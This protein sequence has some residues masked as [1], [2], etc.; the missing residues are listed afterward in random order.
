MAMLC[1]VTE[2]LWKSFEILSV[3]NEWEP[4]PWVFSSDRSSSLDKTQRFFEKA[5]MIV[6]WWALKGTAKWICFL[7]YAVNWKKVLLLMEWK[8]LVPKLD[9]LHTCKFVYFCAAETVLGQISRLNYICKLPVCRKATLICPS[10]LPH[11]SSLAEWWEA[12]NKCVQRATSLASSHLSICFSRL[13]VY[14][15]L[16]YTA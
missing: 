14:K 15:Q 16:N 11:S 2:K 9:I 13:Q 3:R 4:R 7:D 6:L 1:K 10:H 5:E 8:S 12:E